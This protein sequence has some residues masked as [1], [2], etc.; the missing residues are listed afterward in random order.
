[1][2]HGFAC[3]PGEVVNWVVL[4]KGTS[5]SPSLSH[6]FPGEIMYPNSFVE[7]RIK[8]NVS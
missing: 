7:L 1:M 2:D 6:A 5:Q 4:S 8:L 3:Q